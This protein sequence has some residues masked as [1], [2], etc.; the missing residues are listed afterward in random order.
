MTQINKVNFREHGPGSSSIRCIE[1]AEMT[2]TNTVNLE[3]M[4]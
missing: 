2:Q 4:V 1:F 3:N